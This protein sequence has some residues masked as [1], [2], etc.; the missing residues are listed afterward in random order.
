[1]IILAIICNFLQLSTADVNGGVA[2]AACSLLVGLGVHLTQ[3]HDTGFP[4][5]VN[6]LICESLGSPLQEACKQLLDEFGPEIVDG[7]YKN[8]TPDMICLTLGL[9]S[10]DEGRDFCHL[11]PVPEDFDPNDMPSPPGRFTARLN[12]STKDAV[13]DLRAMPEFSAIC[14]IIDK[15]ADKH[16][17]LKDD[18]NDRF[19][20]INTLRGAYWRGRDCN[21]SDPDVYPGRK[22]VD[23]DQDKDHNCNGIFGKDE[24]TNQAYEE[25]FCSGSNPRGIINLGDSASAHFR[26]PGSY[27]EAASLSKETFKDVK[28][29]LT[30]EFDW[31]MLSWITGNM[32]NEWPTSVQG[33]TD[34][35][36]KLMLERNRC[37]KDDYQNIAVNGARSGTM[38][39]IVE[40]I[41]RNA[42]T[43]NPLLVVLSLIG[44]DVCN[45]KEDTKASMTTEE[46][47][48][49]NT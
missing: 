42:E 26:V 21:D 37:I 35:L 20:D 11:F 22:P 40:G 31:P 27:F 24:D 32:D 16:L 19:S 23:F 5:A 36:Y 28:L 7:I 18:D 12:R 8:Y 44:N 49:N 29:L 1:M 14:D 39:E 2:C 10:V 17:P 33:P 41:A 46:E 48:Y 30:N 38:N 4:E 15:F 47:F 9:C 45:G 43:D 25:A 13:D 3:V 34:S 6:D